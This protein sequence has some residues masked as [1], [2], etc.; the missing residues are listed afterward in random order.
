MLET[1]APIVEKELNALRHSTG[2]QPFRGRSA[3]R[4]AAADGIGHLTHDLGEW[5]VF[6]LLAG[7]VDCST[8]Q[9]MCPKTIRL[10]RGIPCHANSAFFSILAP[11]T[12]ICAHC[13]PGNFRLRLHL[14]LHVPQ[15]E[16]CRIRC[17][18]QIRTWQKGKVLV[19]DDSF[20]HEVWNATSS[21]RI[22]LCVDIWHPDFSEAEVRFLEATLQRGDARAVS[23]GHSLIAAVMQAYEGRNNAHLFEGL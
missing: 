19:L 7:G 16:G 13:G 9:A 21:P 10:L 17:S 14:G 22:A 11:G 18:D 5:S 23:N 20:E 12:H 3:D 8:Q 4:P 6:Y 2:F 15:E 1:L